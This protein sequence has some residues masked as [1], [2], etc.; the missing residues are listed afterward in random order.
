MILVSKQFEISCSHVLP[1]HRGK[2]SRLHGH[3]YKVEVTVS[4][5][6]V[7]KHKGKSTEGMV[8][9]FGDLKEI[10]KNDVD[11]QLDH[12]HLNS[13]MLEVPTAENLASFI[14]TALDLTIYNS[15]NEC[16]EERDVEL[17]RVTVWETSTSC[18]I[19]ERDPR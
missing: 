3:N 7:C 18:A 9:D 5:S 16:Q 4:A 10:F 17:Y 14:F 19:V 15:R 11:A 13:Q 6:A 8:L 12:R 1:N 2:C